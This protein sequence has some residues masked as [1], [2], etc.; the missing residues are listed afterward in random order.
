MIW[1]GHSEY[2]ETST[3]H[4]CVDTGAAWTPI[5][6]GNQLFVSECFEQRWHVLFHAFLPR[7]STFTQNKDGQQ[8]SQNDR[9]SGS[10]GSKYNSKCKGFAASLRCRMRQ[11]TS[12]QS[13]EDRLSIG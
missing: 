13:N 12:G 7:P 4:Q 8:E 9:E 6:G 5:I 1:A 2:D 11:F 3:P 10:S